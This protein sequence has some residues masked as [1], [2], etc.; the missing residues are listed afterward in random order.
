MF[1][2]NTS[3]VIASVIRRMLT[4]GK[5][6]PFPSV[7]KAFTTTLHFYSPKAYEYA[8][9]IFLKNLPHP[10]TIR[11]WYQSVDGSPGICSEAI[12]TMRD[13]VMKAKGQNKQIF[14]C[15]MVDE[16]S[17][18]GHIEWDGNKFYGYEDF[19]MNNLHTNQ[20]EQK[21][22]KNAMVF[23]AVGINQHIKIPIAYFLTNSLT[24]ENRAELVKKCLIELESTGAQVIAFTFDG[25]ASNIATAECLGAKLRSV[26][27]LQPYFHHPT[28]RKKIF[29]ILDACHMIKLVRNAL[30][31]GDLEQAT[32]CDDIENKEN[33]CDNKFT[34]VTKKNDFMEVHREISR[35]TRIPRIACCNQ[36]STK[37]LKFL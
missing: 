2:K 36:S 1:Q 18:M 21:E 16:M 13:Q 26:N 6:R 34:T 31:S 3:P 24:G 30:G 33:C 19:G 14:L 4:N 5:N 9:K 8:R 22:A 37:T 15:L 32:N 7:L 12:L 23:M 20:T 11:R 27:D 25:A 35:S 29:I 10:S 17:I 28:T